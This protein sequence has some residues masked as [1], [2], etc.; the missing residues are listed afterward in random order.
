ML[1][2][3]NLNLDPFSYHNN[4]TWM[5]AGLCECSISNIG[6]FPLFIYHTL[7]YTPADES[8]VV[9]IANKY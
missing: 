9:G 6:S 2:I 7:Q 1:I 3:F 8:L 4:L 5:Y